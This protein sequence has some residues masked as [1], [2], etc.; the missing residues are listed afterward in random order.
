M[1]ANSFS[2]IALAFLT[3]FVGGQSNA[4]AAN[5]SSKEAKVTETVIVDASPEQV[6]EAVR[7][8]RDCADLHRKLISFD[9]TT[10][11]IEDHFDHV[12]VYGK[13][14][15]VW[16]EVEH[17]YK[18]IDYTLLSSDHFVSASGR[19]TLT[20]LE[21]GKATRVDFLSSGDAG[22]RIPLGLEITRMNLSHDAKV[23]LARLKRNAESIALRENSSIRE[24]SA[25]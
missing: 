12:P 24:A 13:V 4:Y 16:Q 21:N 15:C 23:R 3:I 14:N 19:W 22:L 9:G 11:K 17:P 7:K 5:G 2:L 10:A 20:P 18:S 8:D 25:R 1:R 6:F